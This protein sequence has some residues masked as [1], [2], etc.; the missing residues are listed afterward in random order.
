MTISMDDINYRYGKVKCLAGNGFGAVTVEIELVEND[1]KPSI[2]EPT[3]RQVT[4]IGGQT[5]MIPCQAVGQPKPRISWLLPNFSTLHRLEWKSFLVSYKILSG[6]SLESV[7][8][9]TNGTL[10]IYNAGELSYILFYKT[11]LWKLGPM[12]DGNYRC[13][14]ANNFGMRHRSI[15]VNII[16][17]PPKIKHKR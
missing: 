15:E 11:I 6:Q 8:V 1:E 14:G 10:V 2:I 5:V 16:L 17:V 3:Y 4:A 13:N 9:D 7:R 12:N